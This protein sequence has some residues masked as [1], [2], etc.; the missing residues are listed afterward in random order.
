M[1]QARLR[2]H[3]RIGRP[4][5]G[6]S[7]EHPRSL[8]ASY[9]ALSARVRGAVI[10]VLIVA[11]GLSAST[12]LA[13]EWRAGA[14]EANRKS[15][16]STAADLSSSLGSRLKSNLSLTRA[17]RS[18][19]TMEPQA[20]ETRFTQWY[21]QLQRGT[22]TSTDVVAVLIQP[23]AASRLAAFK[24]QAEGDPAFRAILGRSFQILP[25]GRRQVYCLTR[26]IVG[27]ARAISLYPGLLDYCAPVLSYVGRSPV[28]SLAALATD[29]GAFVATS[30]PGYGRRS[31]VAVGA[32]VYRLGAPLQTAAERRRAFTGS[33]GTTFDG[34]A[35]VKGV[36]GARPTLRIS[37][38]HQN[39]G[40]RI[41]SLSHAGAIQRGRSGARS[42]RILLPQGWSVGVSGTAE[43]PIAA[44]SRAVLALGL[45][46]LITAL[47]YLLYHVLSRS[48]E[49]AWGLVGER[50]GEL[51]HST[52]HDPLTDLPNRE[53]VLDRAEQ[54]LARARRLGVP[55]T[56]LFM[57]IDD[58]KQ[59]NDR[60]GHQVGD[61]V[62]RQVAARLRSVLR[63]NDTVG[64]LGG[65]EFVMLVDSVGFDATPD[66]LAERVLDV[67]RQPIELPGQ[68]AVT[69]TASIGI[70]TGMPGTA[71]NLMQDADLAL[72]KAKALGKDRYALFESAMHI[73]AQDRIHL[74]MDLGEALVNGELFLVYQPMLDLETERVVGVE[75]LLRWQH[76]RDGVIAP[77]DFIPI[78]EESG[79]IVPIGRWVLEQACTQ[80]AAWHA[81]GHT[82]GVSVNVSTRQLERFAFAA[83]VRQALHTSGLE[84]EM[85]TLEITETVLMRRPD[86]TAR[87]LG[88][89]KTL[90]VRIAVDDFGTGYSSL[91]YLRQFPV[92]SLKI[93]RTF[94]TSLARSGEAQAL[95]HTLIQLGKALGLET[96]AEGVEDR[97]QVV[98]LQ[99]E[100]CDLAQGYLFA[101]PL[102][103]SALERF[104]EDELALGGAGTKR[105]GGRLSDRSHSVHMRRA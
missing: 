61:E 71:E 24:S 30:V 13:F 83:E 96:L 97:D 20:S 29:T 99:R 101:R 105:R 79:L 34:G 21:H 92:D 100:G 28:A 60:H 86:V 89:L 57:D 67:L 1:G 52:L 23:I 87:L 25:P 64:R 41:E 68:A 69:A 4:S 75:A 63:E 45:G 47:A 80:G 51:E 84:P 72:Y 46:A 27:N 55:A 78:A 35:L 73:A 26:A 19:A 38:D 50:T 7:A 104:L 2:S 85:L 43:H 95:A 62:L 17:V 36:L 59:I 93:D 48:R 10:G 53:L 88:D 76:P 66:L 18:I 5:K 6:A 12:F 54:I 58:F 65:D 8:I 77:D 39:P 103:A 33:V 14:L 102:T 3:L 70:A 40:G 94:I 42:E 37:L 56:A 16:A 98:A 74:E 44:N 11:V 81:K 32:A 90:G 9:A 91:A 22:T 82:M 49:R 15:F 31:M